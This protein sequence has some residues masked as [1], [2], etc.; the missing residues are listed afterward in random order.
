MYIH[1]TE[2]FFFLKK[3][4]ELEM[5]YCFYRIVKLILVSVFLHLFLNFLVHVQECDIAEFHVLWKVIYVVIIPPENKM[6]S[7]NL[8]LALLGTLWTH[9]S[10]YLYDSL[11]CV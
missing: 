10:T 7:S 1:E 5:S 6:H 4:V 2:F 8:Y 9:I 3:K 11:L